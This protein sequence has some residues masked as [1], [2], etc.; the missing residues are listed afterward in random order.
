MTIFQYFLAFVVL[1]ICIYA[2]I[3]RVCKCIEHCSTAKAYGN[4]LKENERANDAIL[5]AFNE[6]VRNGAEKEK[7]SSYGKS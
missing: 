3:D 1:Y 7:R 2:L 4:F 6:S 5:N